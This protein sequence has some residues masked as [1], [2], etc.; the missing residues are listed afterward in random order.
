[1]VQTNKF[2]SA[3]KN[4]IAFVVTPLKIMEFCVILGSYDKGFYCTIFKQFH[5]SH[6]KRYLVYMSHYI[7]SSIELSG[8][9][10]S[11]KK[12]GQYPEDVNI[13]FGITW[14]NIEIWKV[15]QRNHK[16]KIWSQSLIWQL[17]EYHNIIKVDLKLDW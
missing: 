17:Q 7:R 2:S 6:F 4:F 16:A 5:N 15:Q 1:M 3:I 13:C 12:Q 8:N 11:L 14:G 10:G 9:K